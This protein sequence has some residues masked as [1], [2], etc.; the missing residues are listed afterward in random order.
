LCQHILFL[1]HNT[2]QLED[3]KMTN[4]IHLIYYYILQILNVSYD[5]R[6]IILSL[7]FACIALQDILC[8][9]IYFASNFSF[10]SEFS[11]KC[12][13]GS[14]GSI[15]TQFP[16]QLFFKSSYQTLSEIN[17]YEETFPAPFCHVE[18]LSPD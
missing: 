7:L 4:M 8:N 9:V 14:N 18:C 12:S 13:Y 1:R 17:F 16:E 10:L 6:N 11:K 2:V 15:L 3:F 5:S